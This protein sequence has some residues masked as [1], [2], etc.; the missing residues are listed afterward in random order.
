[1]IG[2]PRK[3]EVTDSDT[4]FYQNTSGYRILAEIKE[5]ET[6]DSTVVEVTE[7]L[8]DES[9]KIR[10]GGVDNDMS[11]VCGEHTEK[12]EDKRGGSHITCITKRMSSK[13]SL[14]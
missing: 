7:F 13:E 8:E 1:M 9:G 11:L 14:E 4:Q 5:N 10:L 2:E 3:D 12:K 6:E